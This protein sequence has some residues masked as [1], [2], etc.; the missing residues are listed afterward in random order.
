MACFACEALG[1]GYGD[2]FDFQTDA[3]AE[4]PELG[5]ADLRVAGNGWLEFFRETLPRVLEPTYAGPPPDEAECDDGYVVDV[6]MALLQRAHH[7]LFAPLP[8]W[9]PAELARAAKVVAR[10]D[11]L[12]AEDETSRLVRSFVHD[13]LAPASE[14]LIAEPTFAREVR[15]LGLAS[16]QM[17]VLVEQVFRPSLVS[18][19]QRAELLASLHTC[20]P[21]VAS[22]AESAP[23]EESS[24]AASDAASSAAELSDQAASRSQSPVRN[25]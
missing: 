1:G 19:D 24:D 4:R 12:S 16:K 23:E 13:R 8:A 22:D 18:A 17:A 6:V 11:A 20:A 5:S 2:S 15:A 9:L 3:I 21:S 7:V 10:A 14:R 25:K